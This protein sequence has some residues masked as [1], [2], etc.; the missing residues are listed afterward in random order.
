MLIDF[1][2]PTEFEPWACITMKTGDKTKIVSLKAISLRTR[3]LEI[4]ENTEKVCFTQE[5]VWSEKGRHVWETVNS[6]NGWL[7][8]VFMFQRLPVSF[9][10]AIV[11]DDEEK[12]VHVMSE[13]FLCTNGQSQERWKVA[14]IVQLAISCCWVGML[15]FVLAM[16]LTKLWLVA[17]AA[18]IAACGMLVF[19]R[20]RKMKRALK[21]INENSRR[22]M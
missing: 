18:G 21:L 6:M 14:V 10:M 19:T 22:M 15:M 17:T 7:F 16:V 20:I 4:P 5:N 2:F 1:I 13:E 9:E 11:P 12:E 3:R 8:N